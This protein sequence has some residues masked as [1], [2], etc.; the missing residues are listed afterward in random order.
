MLVACS[1]PMGHLAGYQTQ[2]LSEG[3]VIYA[4]LDVN[5]LLQTTVGLLT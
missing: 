1:V 5:S 4:D 3:I 2:T